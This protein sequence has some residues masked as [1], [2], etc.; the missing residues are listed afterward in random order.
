M[1]TCIKAGYYFSLLISLLLVGALFSL[2]VAGLIELSF[3]D[4]NAVKNTP[5][6]QLHTIYALFLAYSLLD[7]VFIFNC[8]VSA[9]R[10]KS[11]DAFMTV[12]GCCNLIVFVTCEALLIAMTVLL[13][14]FDCDYWKESNI[15][16]IA[17]LVVIGLC[18]NSLVLGCVVLGCCAWMCVMMCLGIPRVGYEYL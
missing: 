18:L 16:P 10:K 12:A 17:I 8:C 2:G 13:F 9:M 14:R 7:V 1:F 6:C 11:S 15:Q 4:P 5:Q 3:H